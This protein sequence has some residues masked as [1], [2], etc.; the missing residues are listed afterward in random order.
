[1]GTGAFGALFFAMPQ[2]LVGPYKISAS[3]EDHLCKSNETMVDVKGTEFLS[4]TVSPYRYVFI[5]AS[6]LYG[7][8]TTPVQVMGLTYLDENVSQETPAVFTGLFMICS[9]LGPALGFFTASRLTRI[10]GN[11]G[12]GSNP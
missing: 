11:I 1:M 2:F 7:M 6:L 3:E 4:G 10:P 8:G 12:S 9:L 5:V